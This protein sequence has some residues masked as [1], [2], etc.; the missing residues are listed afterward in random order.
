MK[1]IYTQFHLAIPVTDLEASRQ[2]YRDVLG[3]Q[4]GR[5][6]DN[7]IDFNFY[8]HHLVLHIAPQSYDRTPAMFESK[9]HNEKVIVPHFGLNLDRQTWGDMAERIK[10]QN[11][12]F[13]DPPHV[14]MAGMPGEHATM[15]VVDPSGNALEFKAFKNHDEVFSKIFDPKTKDLSSLETVVADASYQA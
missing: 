13:F 14:R 3:G 5:S 10:T 12:P 2:F 9:F 15:F 1:Q 11:Y 4:E 8:G 6:T 7:F